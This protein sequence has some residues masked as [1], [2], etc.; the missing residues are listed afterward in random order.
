MRQLPTCSTSSTSRMFR[1]RPR[2]VTHQE[3]LLPSAT[4]VCRRQKLERV[5]GFSLG[6]PNVEPADQAEIAGFNFGGF[7][8]GLDSA[9]AA[10][11]FSSCSVNGFICWYVYHMR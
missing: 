5:L 6:A 11:V 1:G 2:Q 7:S 10:C 4:T 3:L 8:L 9:A